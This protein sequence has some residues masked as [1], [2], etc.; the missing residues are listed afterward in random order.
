MEHVLKEIPQEPEPC[1][2]VLPGRWNE[3]P[4]SKDPWSLPDKSKRGTKG[5]SKGPEHNPERR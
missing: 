5:N 3:K 4:C 2:N 1:R